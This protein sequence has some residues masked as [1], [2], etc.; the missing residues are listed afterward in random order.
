[1]PV[2]LFGNITQQL[3]KRIEGSEKTLNVSDLM[4]RCTL[5]AIGKAGFGKILIVKV[6]PEK[7]K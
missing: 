3:F 7:K 1:M 6:E 4:M 5:E 2:K